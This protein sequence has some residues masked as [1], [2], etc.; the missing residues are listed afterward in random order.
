M[1]KRYDSP[2]IEKQKNGVKSPL[3]TRHFGGSMAPL[4]WNYDLLEI[5]S[6]REIRKGDIVLFKTTDEEVWIAHR[7]IKIEKGR[8]HTKG[9][10]NG[11]EDEKTLRA[12]EIGGVVTARWRRGKR[13]VI[14]GGRLGNLQYKLS[15]FYSKFRGFLRRIFG[16]LALPASLQTITTQLLPRPREVLFHKNNRIKKMLYLGRTPIGSYSEVRHAWQIR[17]PYR[18]F[19]ERRH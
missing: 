6:T 17:F 7:V 18:L 4:L 8:I 16:S 9:D 15:R 19:Y 10:N 13:R 5:A 2:S 3:Y 14:Y 1:G 11:M 12:D